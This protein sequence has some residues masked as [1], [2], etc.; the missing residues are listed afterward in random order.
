MFSSQC[1]CSV[2]LAP[3]RFGPYDISPHQA[4]IGV[5]ESYEALG[6]LFEY[7]A[8]FL[9]RLYI[10]TEKIPSSP[11]M[12]DIMVKIMVQVLNV[13]ALATKQI[14]QGRFSKQSSACSS[15]SG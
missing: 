1:V 3:L 13:L 11:T 9:K 7:V 8:N 4:A 6:E 5:S 15:S 2:S 12:S 14:K 10:Y